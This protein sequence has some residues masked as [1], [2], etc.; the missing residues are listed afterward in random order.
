MVLIRLS[1]AFLL[2]ST[3]GFLAA[4]L[5]AQ[6]TFAPGPAPHDPAVPSVAALRGFPTG[7][8]FSTYRDVE[9]VLE[10]LAAASP[11]VRLDTYGSS[12]EGRPL[13]LAWIAS[14]ARLA[15][16]DE[17]RAENR[18]LMAG[19]AVDSTV[20]TTRPIFVW[21]SFGVHGDEASSTEAALEL[22]YHLAASR[23]PVVARWLDEA[24]VVVDPLLNPDGHERYAVWYRS[25]VGSSPNPAPSAR[26]HRPPWPSGRTNHYYF[27]LNRDW[28]WGVQPET[29]A[30]RSVYLATLPHVHVDFHEMDAE[31]SYFFFPP[32]PPVHGL[33]PT[34]TAKWGRIF[35]IANATAFDARGWPYYTEEDFDLFYPGYGDSWPSFYG[36]SGMTYEQAGGGE[37]G[38][39]LER[40]DGS[41]LTLAERVAHHF[42]AALTTIATAVEHREER[43]RDFADFWSPATRHAHG[44]PAAYL[45]VRESAAADSLAALLQRQ[46]VRVDTLATELLAAGLEPFAGTA[47]RE[48][49]PAGTFLLRGDQPL[50]RYLA[51]LMAPETTLPDT[52]LF[53]DITGW[54]LPYLY[55]VP[56]FHAAELP[57]VPAHPWR[58]AVAERTVAASSPAVALAWPYESVA[59]VVAAARLAARG[60]RVQ[61]ATRPFRAGG[62]A[63][64]RGSF[65]LLV[66]RQ[67][68]SLAV[69]PETAARAVLEAGVSA[70]PL[71][72]F[73][74]EDG[75]DLGSSR[76]RQV[77]APRV[78]IAAGPAAEETSVGA[79]WHLLA[80]E[81][82]LAVD[83]VWAEDLAAR[84]GADG[85]SLAGRGRKPLAIERFTAIVLPDGP[86]ADAWASALG[87][88]GADRLARWV[89]AGG[90][91]I[92][93]RAAA[94]WLTA[95]ESGLTEVERI[96]RPEEDQEDRGRSAAER[97][98]D[99]VRRRIPGTLLPAAVDTTA[100][101]GY[102]YPD[103][104]AAILVRDPTELALAEGGN[105]WRYLDRGPLAGF[106]PLAARE[107]LAGQP[108]AVVVEKGR[109][110]VVLFA[111]DPAFRG[112]VHGLEKLYLNA[113]LLSPGS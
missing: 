63:W 84:P 22:I 75:E 55:D 65:V 12:V 19:A 54:T 4:P 43:L 68:D 107:R 5:A 83:V 106:L 8:G 79:A 16:L 59:D 100:A 102:G 80:V 32:A 20:L 44:T 66:P 101:L 95:E 104:E 30:R 113:V 48:S 50:G 25:V 49:L 13:R 111:D 1:R 33:Y 73:R 35:G 92:G 69:T 110:H 56:A 88:E 42:E 91:L 31:S 62:R 27:D 58:P 9:R 103:G 34:T 61:V 89:E 112:I 39:V 15:R 64:R 37:A 17:L 26:E 76:F 94:A 29:R 98:A 2:L 51:A 81:A 24:I 77:A 21:L 10:G 36:A 109:G 7:A 23:D 67:P 72:S 57:A 97:E 108:F 85:D 96:E 82:G 38:I 93:I 46:D 60:W 41:R 87:Q 11:R 78:A 52:S 47:P 99:E 90:T 53:Y 45:L 71:A 40:E 18:S 6:E 14:P 70:V 28:A 74:T 105:A 86:G 3:A